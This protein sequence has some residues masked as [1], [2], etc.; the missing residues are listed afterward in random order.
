MK[1]D[2]VSETSEITVTDIRVARKQEWP[3]DGGGTRFATAYFDIKLPAT[4]TIDQAIQ[5][6][7]AVKDFYSK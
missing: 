6:L 5:A 2:P 3:I 7:Q 4:C 1:T